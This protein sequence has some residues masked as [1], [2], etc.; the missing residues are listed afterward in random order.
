MAVERYGGGQ[1]KG[2]GRVPVASFF[3]LISFNLEIN[4]FKNF[5]I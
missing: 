5:I 2:R 4:E 3:K 1:E